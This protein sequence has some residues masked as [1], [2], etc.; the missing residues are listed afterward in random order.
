MTPGYVDSHTH[1]IFGGYRPEEFDMRL[2][3]AAYMDIMKSGGGI[4]NTVRMTEE[5]SLAHLIATGADRLSKMLSMGITTVE[6]KSGYGLTLETELKQLKAVK[7]L[8]RISPVTLV[9]TFLGAHAVPREYN[10]ADAFIAYLNETVLPVV[11]EEGLAEFVDVFCEAN[12][13]GLEDSRKHLEAAKAM[14]FKLKLHADEIVPLGGAELA[15]SVGAVSADHL[16]HVSDTGIR[17]LSK[18]SV[19]ATLLPAT[20]FTLRESY[21]PA[22]K[23]IDEGCMV[24]LASDFNP[25]SCFTY[26]IPLIISLA[27][28]QMHMTIEEVLTAL[29]LNAAAALGM[30]D[31]IG[32]IEVGKHADLLL[33]AFPS[34]KFIA[35]HVGVNTVEYVIKNGIVYGND[36]CKRI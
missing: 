27:T 33:H 11:N 12:V 8:K 22:R 25:G 23:L 13:F 31:K 3:G 30:A 5:A 20:A 2:K 19:I 1:L 6:A 7:A 15:A 14:G 17:A 21:A 26:A 18:A 34:Y 36:I 24:A 29:T 35:Y 28:L 4:A 16:L 10:S 32:S 9:S